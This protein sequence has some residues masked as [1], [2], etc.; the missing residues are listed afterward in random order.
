MTPQPPQ[1][2]AGADL[3]QAHLHPTLVPHGQGLA[4][5]GEGEPLSE[6]GAAGEVAEVPAGS[7]PSPGGREPLRAAGRRG[8][9]CGRLSPQP[10]LLSP[11]GGGSRGRCGTTWALLG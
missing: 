4:V 9:P 10:R 6:E 1:Q 5:G 7:A 11:S 8:G 3:P 2:V